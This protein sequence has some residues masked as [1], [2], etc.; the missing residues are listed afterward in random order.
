MIAEK[1]LQL[2][3]DNAIFIHPDETIR[4]VGRPSRRYAKTILRKR[5]FDNLL[6]IA[7][8]IFLLYFFLPGME[9]KEEENHTSSIFSIIAVAIVFIYMLIK[10]RRKAE[11]SIF[12]I[13]DQRIIIYTKLH[14]ASIIEFPF[15]SLVSGY[16]VLNH[17]EDGIQ[18]GT[19]SLFSGKTKYDPEY[20][21]VNVYDY[22]EFI[23]NPKDVYALLDLPP[24]GD[25][26]HE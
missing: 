24:Q 5:S 25:I 12:V 22:F 6:L 19:I 23:E 26:Y 4:W 17:T 7:L 8:F 3:Q 11:N 9:G 21:D 18:T 2:L 13:T 16:L 20:G 1:D 10:Q 14:R 15:S